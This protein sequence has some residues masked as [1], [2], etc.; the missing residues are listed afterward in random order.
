MHNSVYTFLLDTFAMMVVAIPDFQILRIVIRMNPRPVPTSAAR[1]DPGFAPGTSNPQDSR[2]SLPQTSRLLKTPVQCNLYASLF[3]FVTVVVGGGDGAGCTRR[4][5][6][7]EDSTSSVKRWLV[8]VESVRGQ[9]L[10]GGEFASSVCTKD[11]LRMV[12]AET[13]ER[14]GS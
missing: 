2:S 9:R 5:W 10:W 7:I 8:Q 4:Y 1:D 13:P 14:L 6:G 12:Y 3:F 11:G